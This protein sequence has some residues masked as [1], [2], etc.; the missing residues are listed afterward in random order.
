MCTYRRS[1]GPNDHVELDQDEVKRV[2]ERQPPPPSD[3][4]LGTP[5]DNLWQRAPSGRK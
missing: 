1:P 5:F 4:P 2:A 3:V